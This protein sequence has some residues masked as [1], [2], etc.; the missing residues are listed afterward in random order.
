MTTTKISSWRLKPLLPEVRYLPSY[1]VSRCCDLKPVKQLAVD[2]APLKP[3]L[4]TPTLIF[5]TR[6]TEPMLLLSCVGSCWW[7][8]VSSDKDAMNPIHAVVV[9]SI[10]SLLASDSTAQDRKSF[11]DIN[12]I[13]DY[14]SPAPNR[15]GHNNPM[16]LS[17]VCLSDVCLSRTS[18]L[19]R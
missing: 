10:I 1:F 14:Y 13:A 11:T 8:V 16:M 2:H 4:T 19:R 18:G 12:S 17:D 6:L 7:T 9:V 15:R 3:L 5:T